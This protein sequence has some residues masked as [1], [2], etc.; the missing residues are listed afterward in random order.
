MPKF[1]F[2]GCLLKEI[3]LFNPLRSA[4]LNTGPNIARRFLVRYKHGWHQDLTTLATKA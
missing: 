1:L 2:A 4:I 3:T